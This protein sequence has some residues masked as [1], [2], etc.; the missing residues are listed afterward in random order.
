[1]LRCP[2][3]PSLATPTTALVHQLLSG[4]WQEP[5]NWFSCLHPCPCQHHPSKWFSPNPN[6]IVSPLL[7]CMQWFSRAS[8][9]YPPGHGPLPF[10]PHLSALY[11]YTS[12]SI[13]I[14][15]PTVPRHIAY[16]LKQYLWSDLLSSLNARSLT[17][18]ILI[19]MTNSY[20]SFKIS[21]QVFSSIKPSPNFSCSLPP[22]QIELNPFLCV[23]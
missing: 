12:H 9:I 6:R 23:P 11:L 4:W 2:T 8:R 5:P 19:P 16:C 14:D 18:R 7:K 10:Q 20:S 21:D 13:N 15:L 1:M 3:A 22:T 17:S